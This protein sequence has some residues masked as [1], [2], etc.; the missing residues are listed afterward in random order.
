[1]IAA[2]LALAAPMQQQTDTTFAV[3][4][5]GRLELENHRG[6]VT[7]RGWDRQEIRLRARHP[8]RTRIRIADRGSVVHVE[9]DARYG[10]PDRVT[11]EIDVPKTY[12]L[13]LEGI[14]LVVDIQDVGAGVEVETVNGAIRLRGGS[15]RIN[16]ESTQGS[17]TIEGTS[18][19][20][21]AE[22]VNEAI[23]ISNSSGDINAGTVNGPIVL[24]GMRANS[25]EA[26]TVNGS[27][28]YDGVISSSGRYHLST[29][30]GQVEVAVPENTNATV[31]IATYN[32]R[33]E[34]DFPVQIRNV[35]PGQRTT[36]TLGNGSA[37]LELESFGG[38]IRLRRPGSRE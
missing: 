4:R 8:D 25:V 38:S 30:N 11:Y 13:S 34:T 28:S 33:F 27:V 24:T 17:I 37:R 23:R 21:I 31:S 22:T 15:G 14:D 1:M 29:H 7:V 32:G 3:S 6:S 12:S 2:A 10:P 35:R 26:S 20:I 16:L 18:G 5:N 36:F 9:A 19:R